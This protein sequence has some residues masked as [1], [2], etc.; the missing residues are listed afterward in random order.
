[1][2]NFKAAGPDDICTEQ[3]RNLGPGARKWVIN[4]FNYINIVQK[5]PKDMEKIK[6]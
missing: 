4:L 2:K 5:N 6:K 3:L 1:M